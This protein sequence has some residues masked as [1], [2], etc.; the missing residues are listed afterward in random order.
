MSSTKAKINLKEGI[1]ELE[2]SEN[3]VIKQLDIFKDLIQ[4]QK[5]PPLAKA[6]ESSINQSESTDDQNSEEKK[7][8]RKNASP[9]IVQPIALDLKK[10]DNRPSLQEFYSTKNPKTAMEKATV[11]AYYL[12]K[13]LNTPKIEAGHVVSCCRAVSTKVPNDIGMTFYNAQKLYAWLQL[14]TSGKAEISIQGENMVEALPR[15]KDVN[16][17]KATA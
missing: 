13:Y 8:R 16:K 12:K 7:H 2:G 14:D 10:T 17:N 11:F 4:N 1:I 6:P 15:N 3:F 9:K 5:S